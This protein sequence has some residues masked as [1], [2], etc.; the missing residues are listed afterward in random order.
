MV[1]A[2]SLHMHHSYH[3]LRYKLPNNINHT[4][5]HNEYYNLKFAS[6]DVFKNTTLSEVTIEFHTDA[7]TDFHKPQA[8]CHCYYKQVV[9]PQEML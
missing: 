5:R 7:L 6:R 2:P 4:A 3:T 8:A 1:R 9:E